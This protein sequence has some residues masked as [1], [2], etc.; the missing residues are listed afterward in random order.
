MA[1]HGDGRIRHRDRQRLRRARAHLP[2]CSLPTDEVGHRFRR[3]RPHLD[4]CVPPLN[5]IRAR[6]A[7]PRRHDRETRTDTGRCCRRRH[8]EDC[9]CRRNRSRRAARRRDARDRQEAQGAGRRR[10]G[11]SRA[12]ASSPASSTPTTRRPAPIVA[13]PMR[14]D[15]RRRR[16]QG[17][18]SRPRANSPPT[19][20]ARSS[21]PSWTRTATRRRSTA[22]AEAGVVAFAMELMPRITR[23]QVDGRAVQPG[24]PRRLPAVIDAAGRIR[25]RL[26]DDDDGGR[27]RAG[28][29]RCSSWASASPACRRSPPRAGSAP[30]S[31]RPTCGRPPRS[32]SRASAPS[33][34]RSRTRSSSRPRPPAATPRKCRRSTRRSRR[35]WSPSTSRSRTS[36]SPPR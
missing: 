36:S 18:P 26:P 15:G 29:A 7:A 3:R 24:Q 28:R 25:P 21:S 14:V 2:A 5:L 33:S 4:G 19:R 12:P 8:H 10:R 16:P 9:G 17:A 34:S 22:M 11:R 1:E 31:P 32:R 35:R 23:A 13:Q 27:H 20:R 6:M 30:S